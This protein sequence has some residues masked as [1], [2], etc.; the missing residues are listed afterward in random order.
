MRWWCCRSSISPLFPAAWRLGIMMIPTIA[1]TTEEMLLMVPN[2]IREAALGL[3]IPQ[4]R[5]TLQVT[6]RTA[7]KGVITGAMLAFATGGGR[8]RSACCSPRSEINF[9]I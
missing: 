5:A 6:L 4:W 1:R 7:S 9:G 2:T 3:G 8:N